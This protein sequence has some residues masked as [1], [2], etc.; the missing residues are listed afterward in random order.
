MFPELEP[1]NHCNFLVAMVRVTVR[2][3]YPMV[4]N[5]KDAFAEFSTL[6]WAVLLHWSTS[7]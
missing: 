2:F 7:A 4:D 6:S 1:R 5:L 3:R